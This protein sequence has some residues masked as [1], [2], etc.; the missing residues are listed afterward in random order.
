[1]A[2]WLAPLTVPATAVADDGAN[3]VVV[4]VYVNDLQDIDIT[5]DNFTADLL[6]WMRWRNPALE[7][8]K[9]LEVMNAYGKDS[10][11]DATDSG[12]AGKPILDAPQI[13][14]DG[15]RYMGVHYRGVFSR[16][17]HLENYPFDTQK[18]RIVL[19]NQNQDAR[20]LQ[21]VPDTDPIVISRAVTNPGYTL[22][23]PSIDVVAHTYQTNFGDLTAPPQ[24][25][26]SRIE[27][28]IPV[29]RQ[30]LPYMVKIM[31]PILILIV[32]TS[33]IYILP[34]RLEDARASVGI[35]AMLTIVA[36][37]WTT[38]SDLPSVGYLTLLDS[39]Y[40]LSMIYILAS[41]IYTVMASRRNRHQMDEALAKSLD[42]KA[43]LAAFTGYLI[44]LAVTV[45]FY[46]THHHI[47]P[48]L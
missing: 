20:A 5:N 30:Y 36:M 9:T 3:K 47:E 8:W 12:L 41:M 15:S 6:L 22:G 11:A 7:P 13:M 14:P 48:R 4:G 29:K 21:F 19:E 33:L 31:L 44:L 45:L 24:R 17:M 46:V 34:P 42:R 27:I 26:Y 37:Q 35:T 10:S 1:M 32:I 2:V 23:V 18:L 38:D 25:D 43:G 16:K 39:I 28:T 40:I